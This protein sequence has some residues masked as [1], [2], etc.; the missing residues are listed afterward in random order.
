MYYHLKKKES[1]NKDQLLIYK[2]VLREHKKRYTNLAMAWIDYK[3]ASDM[4]PQCWIGECL[5]MSG[6][7]NNVQD[8]LNNSMKSWKV[9]LNTSMGKFEEIDISRGIIQGGSLSPLL[10]VLCMILLT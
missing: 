3:K 10:F 8:F 7:V 9:E 4:V 2:T 6:D 1:W 5:E